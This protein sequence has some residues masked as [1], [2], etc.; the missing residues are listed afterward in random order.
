MRIFPLFFAAGV[1]V[2]AAGAFTHAVPRPGPTA[3]GQTPLPKPT[4]TP[5]KAPSPP[6]T[7][8]APSFAAD[9]ARKGQ[10]L[11]Y[12]N[13]A[14]CHG[15]NLEGNVGPA[16]SGGDGNVQWDSVGYVWD[17]MTGHMPA[18]NAGGLRQDEYLDIMSFIL[19]SHG[20]RPGKTMLTPESA[21]ASQALLGPQ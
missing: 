1:A 19:K 7:T 21:K 4:P 12:E 20:H 6:P 18:G 8:T 15:G 16:L 2:L 17:Y 13:C 14:E 5:T 10:T 11:F 3:A 9:Q